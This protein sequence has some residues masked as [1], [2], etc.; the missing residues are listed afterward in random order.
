MHVDNGMAKEQMKEM[1][2]NLSRFGLPIEI[3][4]FDI[5][6]TNGVEKLSEE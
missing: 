4:E 6:M 2:I 1:I 3:T 5:A